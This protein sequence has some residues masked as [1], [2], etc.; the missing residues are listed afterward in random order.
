LDL[1]QFLDDDLGR[2]WPVSRLFFFNGQAVAF[3]LY[4]K[5]DEKEDVP[6]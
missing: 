1:E 3:V 2:V 5:E 6:F 4:E